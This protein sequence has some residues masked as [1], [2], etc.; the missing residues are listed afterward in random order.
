MGTPINGIM[1]ANGTSISARGSFCALSGGL[2]PPP[3]AAW[4]QLLNGWKQQVRA[5]HTV[6]ANA[7]SNVVGGW[8]E[9]LLAISAWNYRLANPQALMAVPLPN[10]IQFEVMSL[11]LQPLYQQI[12]DFR[13]KVLEFNVRLITSNP[14]FA[15]INTS[16]MTL[17]PSFG[18]PITTVDLAALNALETAYQAFVGQCDFQRIVGY[19]SAK[20]SL[21]P[22]SRAE[23]N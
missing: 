7:L 2:L 20:T 22:V 17:P 5:S 23:Q 9:R 11:Y 10:I 21:R 13:T 1:N 4:S 18:Q 8:Y 3:N 14:D 19:M 6:T 16:G 12:V 15:L